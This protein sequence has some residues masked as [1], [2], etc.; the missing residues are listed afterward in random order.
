MWRAKFELDDD[1]MESLRHKFEVALVG[2]GEFRTISKSTMVSRD[3]L[4]TQQQQQQQ[5]R[6]PT[7]S[8]SSLFLIWSIA[9]HIF[10]LSLLAR[11]LHFV[12]LGR[13][14]FLESQTQAQT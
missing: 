14:P 10:A 4:Q 2:P 1:Q 9:L 12:P 8:F 5:R 11:A 6:P 3:N 7:S 13:M